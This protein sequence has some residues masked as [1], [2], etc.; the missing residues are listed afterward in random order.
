MTSKITAEQL[1]VRLLYD[2]E[3]GLFIRRFDVWTGRH[4]NVLIAAEGTVADLPHCEGYLRVSL[5]GRQYLSHRLAWLYMTGE[6]PVNMID[7]RDGNRRNNRWENLRDV[8]NAVNMQNCRSAHIDSRSGLL[9][10]H[11]DEA[12]GVWQ[13]KIMVNGHAI[14]LGRFD[15]PDEAHQAYMVAK[16]H[17]HGE[18]FA[19]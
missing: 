11:W 17:L 19:A 12:R 2:P 6:W 1:R 8:T 13:S 4:R 3:V 18:G 15:T 9:G 16:R 10:A 14:Y 5:F 7:H